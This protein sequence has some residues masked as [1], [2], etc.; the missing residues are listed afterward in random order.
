MWPSHRSPNANFNVY[1]KPLIIVTI[2]SESGAPSAAAYILF[3]CSALEEFRVA[4]S[5]AQSESEHDVT[6]VLI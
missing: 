6:A 4:L 2:P 5:P 1:P 3:F